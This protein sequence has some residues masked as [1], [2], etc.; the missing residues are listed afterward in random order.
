[1]KVHCEDGILLVDW[2]EGGS[3]RQVGEVELVFDGFWLA[4]P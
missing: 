4:A 3:L 2:P 1:L